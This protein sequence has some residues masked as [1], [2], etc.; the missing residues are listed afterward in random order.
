MKDSLSYEEKP[1]AILDCQVWKL[2]NKELVF[3]VL[4]RNQ[5]KEE[6]TWES[7][8][9]L[10]PRY[11]NLFEIVDDDI[12]ELMNHVETIHLS[13]EQ[14]ANLNSH[15]D[16][17]GIFLQNES[18]LRNDR[19]VVQLT[20]P[21]NHNQPIRWARASPINRQQ[22]VRRNRVVQRRRGTPPPTDRQQMARSIGAGGSN[23]IF[24]NSNE[25]DDFT[26]PL[27]D[28]LDVPI[29]PNADDLINIAEEQNDL[30]LTLRL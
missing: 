28:Q 12:K 14:N 9:V 3:K 4:W 7:E 21:S 5:K 18:S 17:D 2:R 26:K 10:R 20:T 25:S 6:A 19:V 16:K 8:D 24:A 15:V 13:S 29:S 1:I 22:M 11:P 27:I 23:S 30:F